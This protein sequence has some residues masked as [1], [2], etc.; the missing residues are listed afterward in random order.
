MKYVITGSLGHISKPLASTLVQAGH[1]VTV[2]SSNAERKSAIE[3]LGAQAAIG[4]VADQSFLRSVFAGADAVY[5][6]VPPTFAATDWKKHIASIGAGYAQAIAAVGLKKVVNLSSIGAHLPDGCGPVSGLFFVEKA[7]NELEGVD[8]LHL[9]PGF[10]YYNFL[11]NIGMIRHMG[12]MG[13]N[14]GEAAKL[15]LS[16]TDDIAAAA[17]EAMLAL[18]FKGNSNKFLVSDE[19]NTQ[20][21]ASTIGAAIGKP[22]LPWVNFADEDSFHGLLQAGLPEEAAKNYVEMGVAMRNGTMAA[23]FYAADAQ[24]QQGTLKLKDFAPTFA[25]IYHAG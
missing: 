7:L 24:K 20:E 10:F 14:Y 19:L 23:E 16:H 15:V 22:E 12:I 9:R 2:I 13:A 5:T 25:A 6:M 8:V 1:Q 18:D 17:A 21:I 4:D 11:G 3:A